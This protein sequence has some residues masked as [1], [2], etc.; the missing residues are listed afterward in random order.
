MSLPEVIK[1]KMVMEV[2]PQIQIILFP[3]YEGQPKIDVVQVDFTQLEG[4]KTSLFMTPCEALELLSAL[5]TAVQFYLYNQEQ[6]RKEILEPREAIVDSRIMC[7]RIKSECHHKDLSAKYE[8]EKEDRECALR[9]S[10][11]ED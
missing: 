11:V 10:V 7:R 1:G 9:N 4:K 3:D 2:S 8:C 5:A 6:Y